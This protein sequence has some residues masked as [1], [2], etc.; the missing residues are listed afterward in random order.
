[1]L[2]ARFNPRLVQYTPPQ[3]QQFYTLLGERI[4]ET[5]GVASAA[6]TQNPPLGLESFDGIAFVPDGF[7]M[8]RDRENF[9][10]ALD[11]VDEGFFSTMGVPIVQGRAFSRSDTSES[12]R[13]AIVNEQFVKHYWPN[14][15]GLGKHLRLDNRSG[16]LVEIVGI[17][18]TV[19][20]R[21]T[22]EKPADFVYVPL[23]Q[24]P[25]PRMVLLMR[26]AG[27]P[28]LLID[29]L[30]EVVRKLDAN[31]PVSDVRTYEDVYRYNAADGPG[32]GVKIVGAMGVVGLL[33]AVA[34]L[35]GLV[36]YTVS[37]RT[38]EIGIRMAIGASPFDVLALVMGQG[39]ALVAI[40]TAIGAV[41]GLGL[42]R[43]LNS[44]L[45]NAGGVDV[46]V[47]AMV[48]PSLVVVTMLAAF[49][50]ARRASKIAPTQALRYEWLFARRRRPSSERRAIAR[51]I[52]AYDAAGR[53]ARRNDRI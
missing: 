53:C 20:Y 44:F 11:T 16:P 17:A 51:E 14:G 32:V 42:E 12:A 43:V 21:T 49:V 15:D 37:R 7:V 13:V 30:K 19:K 4:R 35:Y 29:P 25:V 48:V 1:V 52:A 45:F 28:H 18:Q 24:H 39:V 26:S 31:M 41:M 22:F 2:M 27:D 47:Y 40:G 5:A 34:G 36:A 23:T 3:T 9:T 50:P 10:A 46:L 6:F 33:L 8:P 38:R